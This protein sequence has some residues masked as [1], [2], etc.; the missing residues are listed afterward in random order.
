MFLILL[1]GL[2]LGSAIAI[3]LSFGLGTQRDS[4]KALEKIMKWFH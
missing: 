4:G 1:G 2:A 3:G